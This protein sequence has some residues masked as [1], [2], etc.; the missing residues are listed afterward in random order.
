MKP[1][2]RYFFMYGRLI[3]F[4]QELKG[5]HSFENPIERLIDC[6]Y[7]IN[8]PKIYA[9]HPETRLFHAVNLCLIVARYYIYTAA[10]ENESYSITAFKVLFK[11]T[12]RGVSK[13]SCIRELLAYLDI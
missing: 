4:L 1:N 2:Y 7:S 11:Q 9:H 5:I 3:G 12:I 6:A 13:H 8:G 10:K